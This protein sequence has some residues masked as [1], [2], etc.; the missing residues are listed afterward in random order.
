MVTAVDEI[1]H[2]LVAQAEAEFSSLASR[3]VVVVGNGFSS[4]LAIKGLFHVGVSD[5]VDSEDQLSRDDQQDAPDHARQFQKSELEDGR[6]LSG[7][8]GIA[9]RAGLEKLG[10]DPSDFCAMASCA[11][12]GSDLEDHVFREAIEAVDPESIILLDEAAAER[13]KAVFSEQFAELIDANQARLMAGLV[14]PVLGRRVLALGGFEA[15]LAHEKDKQRV[16]AY[17]KQL[18]PLG[19]PY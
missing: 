10:W 3:G 4:L 9:L 6:L 17:L 13:F 2:A 11:A 16:W 14:V 5:Q 1:K 7:S 12:D 8:D 18:A 15:A 19:A